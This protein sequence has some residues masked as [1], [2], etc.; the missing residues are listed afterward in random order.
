MRKA[1]ALLVI[2][3]LTLTLLTAFPVLPVQ[4]EPQTVTIEVPTDSTDAQIYYSHSVYA[5]A[6]TSATGTVSTGF[7]NIEVGQLD[8]GEYRISRGVVFFD[9]ST[10]P[11]GA[12]IDE[13][14][15]SLYATNFFGDKNWNLTIQTGMPTYPHNPP[16]A[17]DYNLAYYSG[18]LG[19]INV[20]TMNDAGYYN[21]SLNADGLAEISNYLSESVHFMLR[22]SKDIAG[23]ANT[24]HEHLRFW[25]SEQGES[26]TPKLYITY[27]TLEYT[28]NIHGPYLETGAVYEGIINVTASF[29]GPA[30]MMFT[31]TGTNTSASS[32]YF[33]T[34]Y[35]LVSLFWNITS[36]YDRQRVITVQEG[37]GEYY[38]YVPDSEDIVYQVSVGITDFATLTN[39]YAQVMRNVGG[40]NRVIMQLPLDINSGMPFWLIYY[41]QYDFRIVSDQGTFSWSLPAD[42]TT[43]KQYTVTL[44]MITWIY[45]G[46]NFTVSATRPSTENITVTYVDHSGNTTSIT[47]E[48]KHLERGEYVTDYTQTD[49]AASQ[50]FTWSEAATGLS[51]IV[52]ITAT[53]DDAETVWQYGLSYTLEAGFF[54]G[55]FDLFG[56]FPFPATQLI[57]ILIGALFFCIG[58]WRDVEAFTAIGVV[59]T[60]VLAVI[61]WVT[62]PV[63]GLGASFLVVVFMYLSKG[64]RE[65]LYQ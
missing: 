20:T 11:I 13:A 29:Q 36:S 59:V 19:E 52:T 12:V 38:L 39:A 17:G 37:D 31:L 3:A 21:I 34:E 35:P 10:I 57:G 33:T 27:T 9:L 8:V 5:T 48:I 40:T 62:V 30:P 45:P 55:F 56:S 26:T 58:N 65:S 14:Y 1:S 25:A 7:T 28:Y 53:I 50:S 4:A 64:K 6:R 43:T 44:D 41:A 2:L 22:S 47:T 46:G 32:I 63:L 60:A 61:G 54:T 24:E 23:T 16:V 18:N 49:L 42:G 15:L 51:Y